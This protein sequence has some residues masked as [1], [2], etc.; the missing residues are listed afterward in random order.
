MLFAKHCTG[1]T[2]RFIL[3]KVYS[4]SKK[5]TKVCKHADPCATN[6][7]YIHVGNGG[8]VTVNQ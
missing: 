4:K 2:N 3:Y 1:Q 5:T 6:I 7:Q 8:H